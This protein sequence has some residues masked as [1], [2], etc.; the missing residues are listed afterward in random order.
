MTAL[1]SRLGDEEVFSGIWIA[2][3]SFSGLVLRADKNVRPVGAEIVTFGGRAGRGEMSS[4]LDA[5]I[6]SLEL[7][8]ARLSLLGVRL[9]TEG[10]ESTSEWSMTSRA[11]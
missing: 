7:L 10:A 1:G 9:G 4:D 6:L 8:V 5:V 3:I 11:G 2:W